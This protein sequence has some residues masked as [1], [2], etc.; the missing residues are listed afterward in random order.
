VTIR[1][2]AHEIGLVM[3]TRCAGIVGG[4]DSERAFSVGAVSTLIEESTELIKPYRA[5]SRALLSIR[6]ADP[7]LARAARDTTS[8]AVY[9]ARLARKNSYPCQIAQDWQAKGWA[10]GKV[11]ELGEPPSASTLR[12]VSND[13]NAAAQRLTAAGISDQITQSLTRDLNPI[14]VG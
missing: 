5:Y 1:Q 6:P 7:V 10:R 3:Q 13:A 4:A 2:D 9:M 14:A 12:T 8:I 11:P